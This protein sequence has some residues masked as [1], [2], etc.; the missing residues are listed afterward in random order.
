MNNQEY[1][2]YIESCEVVK[3]YVVKKGD[4]FRFLSGNRPTD[5]AKISQIENSMKLGDIMPPITVDYNSRYIIDGQ[6]RYKAYLRLLSE[7]STAAQIVVNFVNSKNPLLDAI[8]FNS[9]QKNW[10]LEDYIKAYIAEN[11]KSYIK[12]QQFIDKHPF[13]EK[14]V[15]A[16]IQLIIGREGRSFAMEGTLIITDE[17]IERAEKILAELN[18]LVGYVGTDRIKTADIVLSWFKA[19]LDLMAMPGYSFEEYVKRINNFK[20]PIN[21]TQ[22]LWR[23]E[24]L[25]HW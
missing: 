2:D 17:M 5:L 1:T 22:S 11:R 16:A 7:N 18:I 8:K 14:N 20:E 15:K 23:F 9:K 6:H 24:Y 3:M 21:R 12:L 19:R 10:K 25:R 13:Y 4:P